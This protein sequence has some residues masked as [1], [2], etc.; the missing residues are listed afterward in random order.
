[1]VTTLVHLDE[2]PAALCRHSTPLPVRACLISHKGK[3]VEWNHVHDHVKY[4]CTTAEAERIVPT[5][6]QVNYFSHHHLN[7][8]CILRTASNAYLNG[9]ITL[10]QLNNVEDIKRYNHELTFSA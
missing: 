10:K 2:P 3:A 7:L 9:T 5:G 8:E 1:M 6:C 4:Y